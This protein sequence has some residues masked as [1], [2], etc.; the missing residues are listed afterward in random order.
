[1]IFKG[2][3]FFSHSKTNSCGVAIGYYGKRSFELLSKFRDKSGRVLIIEVKIKNV[4]LLLINQ[5]EANMENKQLSM[6]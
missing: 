2:N 5:Y 3:Y 4:V 1:M 6:L